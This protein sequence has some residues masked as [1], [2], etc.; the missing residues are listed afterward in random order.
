MLLAQQK[1]GTPKTKYSALHYLAVGL[2]IIICASDV[3]AETEI[4]QKNNPFD[5]IN[6][7]LGLDQTNP[8]ENSIAND[9][10]EHLPNIVHGPNNPEHSKRNSSLIFAYILLGLFACI[11]VF[12][13]IYTIL[14]FWVISR[15]GWKQRVGEPED[16][17]QISSLPN[18]ILHTNTEPTGQTDLFSS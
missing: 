1:S 2:L 5:Q 7:T 8:I 3:T 18:S 13:I 12:Y 17:D 9:F 11:F 10:N 14:D 16:E 6:P 15:R 4:R